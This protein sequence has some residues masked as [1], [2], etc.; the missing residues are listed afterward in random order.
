MAQFLRVDTQQNVHGDPPPKSKLSI[1]NHIIWLLHTGT[2]ACPCM[3][4]RSFEAR[5]SPVPCTC[6]LTPGLLTS[7][8]V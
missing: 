5:P 8:A 7:H 1:Q 4:S 2:S 6:M 3:A